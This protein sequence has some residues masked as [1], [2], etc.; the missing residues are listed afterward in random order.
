MFQW[1]KRRAEPTAEPPTERRSALSG[2]TAEIFAARESYL[3]G[4]RGIGE[5][6]ATVQSCVTLWES[7]M[8]LADVQGADLLTRRCMALAARGLALRG[9]AVFLITADRLVP[10]A[11][12]DVSTRDGA[13]RAYRLSLPDA[14]GGRSVTALAGEVLHF[15]TASDPVAP[16]T[17][18]APL[19]RAA[20]TAQ[21]LHELESALRDVYRDGPLGTQMV[22]LPEGSADDMAAMRAAFRGRRGAVLVVEGAANAMAAGMHPQA[23][24]RPE[25]LTPDLSRAM[26]DASLQAARG[27]ICAAFGVLPAL[28]QPQA[29]GP[30]IREAQRHLAG[31]VLQPLAETMA[32]EARAKLGSPV[33][34]DVIR[35]TQAF[36]AG[37]RARALLGLIE[38]LG[39][40][41]ELGLPPE[42]L[43]AALKAVNWGGGDDLA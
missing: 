7:A 10:V 8:A 28:F 36:D 39:R 22:P 17:G 37:G 18:Q 3:S 25:Q 13:P 29:Q 11:D 41:K 30:A 32:E 43:A 31:W 9:E 5:L 24:Q 42:D 2:L 23:G 34:I 19:R 12:W 6:T 40:A 27:A 16:W 33:V 4:A 1:L 35:A 21:L 38:G 20:I 14:G 15:T 26:T